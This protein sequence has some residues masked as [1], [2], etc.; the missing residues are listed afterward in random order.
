LIAIILIISG[1]VSKTFVSIYAAFIDTII[2][3]FLY[4]KYY[5]EKGGKMKFATEEIKKIMKEIYP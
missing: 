2:T 4:D 3:C 1:I 5:T